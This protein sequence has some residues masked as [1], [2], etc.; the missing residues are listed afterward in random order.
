MGS[1]VRAAQASGAINIQ[2]L[3]QGLQARSARVTQVVDNGAS[4]LETTIDGSKQAGLA[5]E[6]VADAISQIS[7]MNLA[8][9]GTLEH[10]AD[11]TRAVSENLSGINQLSEQSAEGA[12]SSAAASEELAKA[13]ESLERVSGAYQV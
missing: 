11:A 8:I 1:S 3:I 2:D 4:L 5:F 12:R 13:A 7:Q 6:Q 9:V 10:Q